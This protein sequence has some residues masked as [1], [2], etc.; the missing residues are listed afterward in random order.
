MSL[1]TDQL[2]LRH[3]EGD[4]S[5]AEEQQLT[6]LLAEDIDVRLRF[7]NYIAQVVAMR[8]LLHDPDQYDTPRDGIPISRPMAS[9]PAVA[10]EPPKK[11]NRRLALVPFR[12]LFALIAAFFRLRWRQ[13]LV[14]AAAGAAMV[15]VCWLLLPGPGLT[16]REIEDVLASL[17]EKQRDWWDN[18]GLSR[19]GCT[20]PAGALAR[21][22]SKQLDWWEAERLTAAPASSQTSLDRLA[23]LQRA[24]WEREGL[25]TGGR[26]PDPGAALARLDEVNRQWLHGAKLARLPA[27]TA[28]VQSAGDDEEPSA[29]VDLADLKVQLLERAGT[30]RFLEAG[31]TQE[32]EEAVQLG[33]QW[34][35]A[36]QRAD[37]SWAIEPQT[38]HTRGGNHVTGTAFALLPFLARG[39]TH[40]GAQDFNTYSKQVERGIRYLLDKQRA[41]GLLPGGSGMYTHAV[42]AIALCEDFGMTADPLL[43]EPSQKA[44]DYILR[45]QDPNGGGWRY[46][47][48]QA[49][50]LS[51]TSWALM[52]L[53]IGQI[54]GLQVPREAVEKAQRFLESTA[55][56]DGGYNYM[57]NGDVGHSE[58]K[59]AVMT[60]AGI[61]CRQYLANQ[62]GADQLGAAA[63]LRGVDVLV[64]NPPQQRVKNYYYWYY[65]TYALLGSGG[66]AWRDWNPQVRD[67]LVSMQDR[68]ATNPALKGSWD[69]ANS[70]PIDGAGRV[71]VTALALLTLEVYY[72]HLPLNRPELGEMAKDLRKK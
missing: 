68:G 18:E 40:R 54:D 20:D 53:K 61:V 38:G 15:G 62:S 69:P 67:L 9:P 51:V 19:Q 37:G 48:R 7:V 66:D 6:A 25:H 26:C 31:G 52:A 29:P 59:P 1:D 64:K 8:E 42:A 33:L 24:W 56:P 28:V 22:Q 13:E 55:R 21:L 63:G 12:I 5:P 23:E 4:T 30:K 71:G 47:P 14:V 39:E 60:A 57:P 65:A 36:Q 58:P 72:R 46:E 45:A 16:H 49:G 41:D 50:D 34:L 10:P 3:L 44:I 2:I 17:R 11:R 27:E 32:S 43:R 35:A 70:G